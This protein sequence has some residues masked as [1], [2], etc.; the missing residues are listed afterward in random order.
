[1]ASQEE[2]AQALTRLYVL[3]I[4]MGHFAEDAITW[5]PHSAEALNID[6]CREVGLEHTAI[7]G[8]PVGHNR[9][10]SHLG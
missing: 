5:P 4:S 1:M 10:R 9:A 2:I 3:L 8:N 6:L 7:P